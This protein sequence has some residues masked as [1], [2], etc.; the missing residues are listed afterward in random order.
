MLLLKLMHPEIPIMDG[1]SF[2]FVAAIKSA[3]T[4]EQT[5]QKIY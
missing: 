2:D 3:G 4:Q 5:L 1:S